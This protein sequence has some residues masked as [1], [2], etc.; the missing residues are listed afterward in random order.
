MEF[1]LYALFNQREKVARVNL[2]RFDERGR[3]IEVFYLDYAASR[4]V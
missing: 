2:F 4:R 1:A 3:F